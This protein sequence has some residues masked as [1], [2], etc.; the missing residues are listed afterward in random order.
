MIVLHE[1]ESSLDSNTESPQDSRLLVPSGDA[2]GSEWIDYFIRNRR[3]VAVVPW[4][5]DPGLTASER[6]A[7]ASSIQTFQLGE[8]GEGKY[9]IACAQRW[10]NRRGGDPDYLT[11]LMMFIQEENRHAAWLGS[12]LEQEGIPRLTKQW[13]DGWFRRLRHMAGLRTSIVVL[14]TAEILAQVYYLALM[15]ATNSPTLIAI[16]RRVLRDERAHVVFQ[17]GQSNKL[18]RGWSSAALRVS[19]VAEFT[20][21]VIARRI[22]WHDHHRVFQAARM[23]WSEFERRTRTRWLASHRRRLLSDST[24]IAPYTD[25]RAT[26][27]APSKAIEASNFDSLNRWH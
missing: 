16:C 1:I 14:V 10:I 17:Q 24:S 5:Q 3:D 13:S 27:A 21:F 6:I 2:P 18:T 12:F 22:V 26:Q 4:S 23:P 19:Y 7:V 8:S 9:I 11:A 15:K 20:L 25:R